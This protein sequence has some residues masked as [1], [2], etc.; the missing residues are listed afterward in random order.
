MEKTPRCVVEKR[1]QQLAEERGLRQLT[2]P[3]HAVACL[4]LSSDQVREIGFKAAVDQ[5][6]WVRDGLENL[7]YKRIYLRQKWEIEIPTPVDRFFSKLE[8]WADL[9]K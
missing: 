2:C 4:G 6:C 9:N 7:P 1:A 8:K 5:C 3:F